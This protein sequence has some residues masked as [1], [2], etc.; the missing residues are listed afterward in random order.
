MDSDHEEVKNTLNIYDKQEIVTI[1][2]RQLEK[3]D[4][5][6]GGIK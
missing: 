5:K 6:Q 3:K 4:R 2:F 1:L